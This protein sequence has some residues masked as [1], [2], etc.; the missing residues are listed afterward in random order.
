MAT[1]ME[2]PPVRDCSVRTCAYNRQGCHAF[3]ITVGSSDRAH[4]ET[5]IDL[6][7]I[8]GFEMVTAQVGACKRDDCRYNEGLTCHAPMITIGPDVDAADCLTYDPPVLV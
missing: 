5:F 6:P 3:A 4:C 7:V 2:M 8:G 1:M